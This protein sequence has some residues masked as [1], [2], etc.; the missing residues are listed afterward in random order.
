[1]SDTLVI[2]D[3][4]CSYS[5]RDSYISRDW[6]SISSIRMTAWTRYAKT[7]HKRPF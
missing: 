2:P 5:Y 1:M 6:Q 4:P 3:C 7:Y